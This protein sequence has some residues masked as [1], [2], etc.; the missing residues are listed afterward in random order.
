MLQRINLEYKKKRIILF[1]ILMFSIIFVGYAVTNFYFIQKFKPLDISK[2]KIVS[3][4]EIV[5]GL[6]PVR[7]YEFGKQFF[8]YAYKPGE[9]TKNVNI[10]LVLYSENTKEY[11][12]VSTLVIKRSDI[13]SAAGDGKDH[14]YCGFSAQVLNKKLLGIYKI[15][16]LYQNNGENYLIDTQQYMQR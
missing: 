10:H 1:F 3:D 16:I 12:Q 8:G 7:D 5:T 9:D 6:D 4:G 14:T 13:S 2:M 15:Y 11:D